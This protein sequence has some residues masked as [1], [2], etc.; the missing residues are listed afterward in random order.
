MLATREIARCLA[1]QNVAGDMLMKRSE[2]S[3]LCPRG[4]MGIH[5]VACCEAMPLDLPRKRKQSKNNAAKK[6]IKKLP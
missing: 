1:Q 3:C 4:G 2:C 5:V 6:R